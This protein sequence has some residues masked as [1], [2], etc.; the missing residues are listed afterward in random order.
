MQATM[1]HEV[2]PT[3]KQC[4]QNCTDCHNICVETIDH[5]LG[6]GGKHVESAHL[7]SLLD[8]ADTCRTSADFMLRGSA[9]YTQACGMCAEACARCATSCEQ[10]DGDATMK[11]CAEMCRRCA[12]S[13]G[14]MA[15][16]KM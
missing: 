3:M 5:C 9:A 2:S 4:I 8:C 1:K 14:E 15:K 11:A 12:Q 13:C 10:F 16:M 6:M 7:K